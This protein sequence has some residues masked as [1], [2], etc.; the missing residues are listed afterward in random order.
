M[1]RHIALASTAYCAIYVIDYCFRLANVKQAWHSLL[2]CILYQL[3]VRPFVATQSISESS[4][5]LE[6]HGDFCWLSKHENIIEDGQEES[7]CDQHNVW[8]LD[9]AQYTSTH[10]GSGQTNLYLRRE[11]PALFQRKCLRVPPQACILPHW[12]VSSIHA[13]GQ[14]GVQSHV[15]WHVSALRGEFRRK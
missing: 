1:H 2:A 4:G 10:T 7:S 14:I 6:L 15:N 3:D 12:W 5:V 13:D 9:L 11:A 8:R